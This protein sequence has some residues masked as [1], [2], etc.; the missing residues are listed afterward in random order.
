[1]GRQA[2][3]T[4]TQQGCTRGTELP[5]LHLVTGMQARPKAC[6]HALR[7]CHHGAR[8]THC[9]VQTGH[10]LRAMVRVDKIIKQIDTTTN[11]KRPSMAA[12]LAVQPAPAPRHH[13]AQPL[14]R[15]NRCHCTPSAA[16]SSIQC[17]GRGGV[18][19]PVHDNV[20]SHAAAGRGGQRFHHWHHSAFH[21]KD[22][23][24]PAGPRGS[25]RR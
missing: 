8:D 2:R 17:W 15:Q 13:D 4:A 7:L 23:G 9:V 10:G 20:H 18:P 21:I 11:N 6:H 24:S 22:I 3:T 12:Q 16:N 14:Q 1:M 19:A 25:W 5:L